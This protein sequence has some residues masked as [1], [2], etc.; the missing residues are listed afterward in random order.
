MASFIYGTMMATFISLGVY[1]LNSPNAASAQNE[2]SI[3]ATS[4]FDSGQF[5][6]FTIALATSS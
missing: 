1:S 3:N 5:L 6:A 2:P 4:L